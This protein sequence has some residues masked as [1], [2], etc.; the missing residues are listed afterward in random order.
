MTTKRSPAQ[1]AEFEHWNAVL[2]ADGLGHV[3]KKTGAVSEE[4][5]MIPRATTTYWFRN[6]APGVVR[7]HG[8]SWHS[9]DKTVG[10]ADRR[11]RTGGGFAP[12]TFCDNSW[13]VDQ[14][15]NKPWHMQHAVIGRLNSKLA[16]YRKDAEAVDASA[17]EGDEAKV[18]QATAAGISERRLAERMGI[19]RYALYYRWLAP[20]RQKLG[21]PARPT[22]AD[23][24]RR[25]RASRKT[26]RAVTQPKEKDE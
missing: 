21:L 20:I 15:L 14:E 4:L 17:L 12:P 18:W 9:Y 26:S 6:V 1:Q 2:A 11:G 13:L 16:Q 10:P 23:Y 24:M 25:Y 8:D 3:N 7:P 19:T 5:P 22:I